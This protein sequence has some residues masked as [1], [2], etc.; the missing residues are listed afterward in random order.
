MAEEI[1]KV[2]ADRRPARN[3]AQLNTKYQ[4]LQTSIQVNTIHIL[5]L[6]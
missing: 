4:S 5:R 2:T 6:F 3:V 1:I